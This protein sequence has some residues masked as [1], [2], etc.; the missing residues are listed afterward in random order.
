MK[1]EIQERLISICSDVGL[2]LTEL[3]TESDVNL[4]D[5]IEDSLQF[6]NLIIAIE[7]GFQI[8]MPDEFLIWS[9]TLSFQALMELICKLC[10]D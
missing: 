1:K 10:N 4:M 3:E 2:M 6:M 7:E 8:E 5:Q 9:D